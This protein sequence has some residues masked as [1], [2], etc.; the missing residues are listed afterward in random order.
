MDVLNL[1][2]KIVAETVMEMMNTRAYYVASVPEDC[3]PLL[4]SSRERELKQKTKI[5][6]YMQITPSEFQEISLWNLPEK[7][8]NSRR[9]E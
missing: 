6:H 5:Q 7:C 1:N 8:K 9:R 3:D 2:F 4:R